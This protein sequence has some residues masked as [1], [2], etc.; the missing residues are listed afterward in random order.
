M[1]QNSNC[2]VYVGNLSWKVKWQDLKDHMK[3]VGEVVRADIIEDYDGKSKGCGLVEFADEETAL[4][5]MRE[6]ND[7]MIYDRPI[8]IREDREGPQS[9]RGGRR[10]P[11]RDWKQS[12]GG[13]GTGEP[14]GVC[15][16][17]TNIQWRTSWQ[18]LKDLFKT[19]APVNRVD[20]LT[21]EDGKSKGVAKVY[22]Q[23]EEDAN[24]AISTFND[25]LLDGRK[26]SVK[27]EQH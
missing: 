25:Y 21:R 19:C 16:L 24:R 6:L 2:R 20:I 5:A 17:V 9:F 7:T 18:D 15:V 8:F 10:G 3:Q 1:S 14:A 26:I 11:N 13:N 22:F 27:F 4:R 12:G 23:N